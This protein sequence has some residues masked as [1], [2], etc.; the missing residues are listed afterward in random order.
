MQ[1]TIRHW[2][3]KSKTT[4]KDGEIY[5]VLGFK[6]SIFSKWLYT[7]GNLQI[8]SNPYQIANGMFHRT[9]TKNFTIFVW[10]HKRPPIAK[11]ILRKKNGAG[12]INLSDFKL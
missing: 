7:K 12:G 3:N 4:Q 9:R 6:E 5:H 2:W 10:K 8:Q 11:A 1:K